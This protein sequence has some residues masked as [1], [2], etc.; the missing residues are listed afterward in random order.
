[1]TRRGTIVGV[2]ILLP[3]LFP[4]SGH[5]ASPYRAVQQGNAFYHAGQFEAAAH[6]YATAGRARPDAAEIHFNQGN[7]LYKQQQYKKA[8][9]HYT[10]ALHTAT[11]DLA[12]RIKY[13]LGNVAYQRALASMQNR[14]NALKHLRAAITYYRDSLRINVQQHDTRYNL[15]LA[16]RLQHQ[17][18]E[19]SQQP[20]QREVA[21]AQPQRSRSQSSPPQGTSQSAPSQGQQA[22]RGSA[23]TLPDTGDVGAQNLT[24]PEALSLDE[25]ERQLETIRNRAREAAI[26]RRQWRRARLRE[27]RGTDKYW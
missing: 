19:Q 25:A 17:L 14:Q 27:A 9:R 24:M 26:L 21:H 18:L 1:M 13:N 10:H 3:L 4:W 15:E 7:A 2:V 5:A 22:S 11:P 23:H 8:L 20:L 12:S 6:A 16:H